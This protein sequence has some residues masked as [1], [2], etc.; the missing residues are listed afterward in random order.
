MP[1]PEPK[2]E[3][4]LRRAEV[5]R[6]IG[7]TQPTLWTWIH[8]GIFP[9]SYLLSTNAV[10]WK[11]SQ[12]EA[13]IASRVQGS[14]RDIPRAEAAIRNSAAVR[15]ARRLAGEAAATNGAVP[16]KPPNKFRRGT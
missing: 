8:R 14:G 7:V 15:T 5:L 12:V 10:A 1:D 3:R 9:Q 16:P 4:F 2:P 13:W 11:E 6:R